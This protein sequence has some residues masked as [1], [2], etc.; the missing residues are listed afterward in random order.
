MTGR[1]ASEDERLFV[2]DSADYVRIRHLRALEQVLQQ[3]LDRKVW[4]VDRTDYRWE[5]IPFD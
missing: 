1:I 3:L 2:L 5:I 4:I